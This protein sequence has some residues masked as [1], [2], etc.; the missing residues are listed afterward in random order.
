MLKQYNIKHV[1]GGS[2]F[3][4][5]QTEEGKIFA[6]GDGR[7]CNFLLNEP[8]KDYVFTPIETNIKKDAAFCVVVCFFSIAFIG[9]DPLMSPNR[10]IINEKWRI[11]YLKKIIFWCLFNWKYLEQLYISWVIGYENIT[12]F[13][14]SIFK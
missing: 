14:K 10:T 8:I 9:C 3:S 12:F 11:F 1:Y 6:C 4:L 7:Y 2:S 13:M 5:F